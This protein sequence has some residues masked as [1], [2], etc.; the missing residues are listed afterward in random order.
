MIYIKALVYGRPGVGKTWFLATAANAGRTL[1]I[2]FEG[3][4]KTIMRLPH[5]YELSVMKPESYKEFNN[6]Y[7]YLKTHVDLCVKMKTTQLTKPEEINLIAA[8]RFFREENL[9]ARSG[10]TSTEDAKATVAASGK[11][12][13]T[14]E[15]KDI[16]PFEHVVIDSLTEVQVACMAFFVPNLDILNPGKPK[17][18]DWGTNVASIKLL[19]RLL[20]DLDIHFWCS[21]LDKK[22]DVIIS[23]TSSYTSFDLKFQ[24]SVGGDVAALVD[25]IAYMTVKTAG[26]NRIRSF[27]FVNRPDVVAKDR[28]DTFGPT[29]DDLTIPK[30]LAMLKA[31]EASGVWKTI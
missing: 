7:K 19:I 13:D 24:G 4:A 6:I 29:Q 18:Q 14:F 10:L 12:P 8:E 1:F 3:G 27:N 21:T 16:V 22:E 15:L 26:A 20:R 2:D 17:I 28:L 5:T 9:I 25:I 23:D 11:V 31:K 30:M